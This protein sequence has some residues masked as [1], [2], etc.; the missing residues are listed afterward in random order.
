M[1]VLVSHKALGSEPG[2]IVRCC[3]PYSVPK[4]AQCPN[5]RH[6]LN[7]NMPQA[8]NFPT[9][10]GPIY[11]YQPHSVKHGSVMM[12]QARNLA[13]PRLSV[14]Y[15]PSVGRESPDVV[16]RPILN[17][18]ITL[19]ELVAWALPSFSCERSGTDYKLPVSRQ[20]INVMTDCPERC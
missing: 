14:Q 6:R 18:A 7:S 2:R 15:S 9:T 11:Q 19:A 5:T 13:K 20:Y 3:S 8:C 17:R 4:K 16:Y 10:S 12:K 1:V